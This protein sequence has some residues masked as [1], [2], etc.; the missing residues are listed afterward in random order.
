[1]VRKTKKTA[2]KKK[3][4]VRTPVQKGKKQTI[5]TEAVKISSESETNAFVPTKSVNL[6]KKLFWLCI[7]LFVLEGF[8]VAF[9][10]CEY[11]I[12]P[13]EAVFMN[14]IKSRKIEKAR[15]VTSAKQ[16]RKGDI[17]R[18][19]KLSPEEVQIILDEQKQTIK[20]RKEQEEQRAN[21]AQMAPQ[22]KTNIKPIEKKDRSF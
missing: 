13:R 2:P 20:I 11:Q 14:V 21:E 16:I 8:G 18:A 22:S 4:I 15:E 12:V 6:Y 1:M 9:L 3:N 19:R 10:L 5:K 17:R 7:F